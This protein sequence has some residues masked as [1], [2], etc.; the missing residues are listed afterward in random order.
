MVS[1]IEQ[2]IILILGAFTIILIITLA[3]QPWLYPERVPVLAL[4][5]A[6]GALLWSGANT[7]FTVFGIPKIFAFICDFQNRYK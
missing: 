6:L 1:G 3:S 7:F 2:F 4:F 5:V